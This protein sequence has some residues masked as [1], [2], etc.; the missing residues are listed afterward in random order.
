MKHT[1]TAALLCALAMSGC[2][3]SYAAPADGDTPL[4]PYRAAVQKMKDLEKA[5]KENKTETAPAATTETAPA[6][7]V[8]YTDALIKGLD[9]TVSDV[10]ASVEAGTFKNLSPEAPKPEVPAEPI[11]QPEITEPEPAPAEETE[12]PAEPE[13]KKYTISQG[14]ASNELSK[15][16]N[17][18]NGVY[19]SDKADEN[20]LRVPMAYVTA[21]NAQI[22]KSGDSSSTES[23]E[24]YGQNAAL[25]ATHGGRAT[26]TGARISSTGIGATGAYGYS[27]STYI[28]LTDS[29]I[30][31]SGDYAAG[32]SVS[33]RAMMKTSNTAVSTS[34]NHSPAIRIAEG[35]GILIAEGGSFTTTGTQ[36]HGIYSKG[37]VTVENATVKAEK[38]KAA[39]LKGNDTITLTN[40]V[41][42]GNETSDA[43]PH[44][45]V[46]F[47][48]EKDIGTMGQQ[49][50]EVHGGALIA[51]KGDMF[52][53]T[54]TH[55]KITLN[56]TTLTKDDPSANLITVAGN[57]GANG[58]GTPGSNGGHLELI[59]DGQALA[60]NI[61]V[62]T[63]SNINITL[64]NNS[65]YDGA[66]NIVPN[67]E[68]GEKYKTNADVFVAAG[69]VWNLTGDSTLTSLYNLGTINYN[70]HTVTLAGGT[71]MKG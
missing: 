59:C 61:T 64:K 17:Y 58:W 11:S 51:H 41:L 1:K 7:E 16:G 44:N 67:A 52:Y 19:T 2:F 15:D 48:D 49:H 32:V 54:S 20:A 5:Q 23:S 66:I 21:P 4:D 34:G 62:D 63:I 36:S 47:S 71:V 50:F 38:S 45:I 24:L 22:T 8:N 39:V 13:Q 14:E 31:T 27:K 43:V 9:L 56:G 18:E 26:L 53:V 29:D 35:G 46:I 28:N 12:T 68:G 55:G 69:S 3:A 57:D 60:G 30:S 33:T 65:V 40:T 10:Q 37:D 25:L 42:E 70:G 6:A